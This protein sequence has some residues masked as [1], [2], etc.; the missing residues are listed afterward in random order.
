LD[1][2]HEDRLKKLLNSIYDFKDM[3]SDLEEQVNRSVRDVNACHQALDDV[4]AEYRA[5]LDAVPSAEQ[6][7]VERHYGRKVMDLRRE[8]SW[9]PD[10]TRGDSV[11]LATKD[12]WEVTNNV[13]PQA[14]T[15][16][17][18][19]VNQAP[20][21]RR[22]APSGPRVG[23][24]IEAWCGPCSGLRAHT[25]VAMVGEEPKQV[26]CQ[27]CDTKH[28]YRLTPARGAKTVAPKR[29]IKDRPTRAEVA[30]QREE[31]EQAALQKELTEAK[32]VRPFNKRERYRV[33]EIIEHPE[34]GRGKV[35]HVVRG[36]TL[37]RFRSGPRP[38]STI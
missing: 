29:K 18:P 23:G 24:E 17:A 9:L 7:Q 33:G 1:P 16:A 13:M 36:S 3:L 26:I 22:R 10:R 11:P 14:N 19:R 25:I 2:E 28:G 31:A 30:R 32:D 37:I 5:I 27:S 38:I 20:A 8:A 15:S 12:Q 21:P 34:Y 6:D 35:E 4:L